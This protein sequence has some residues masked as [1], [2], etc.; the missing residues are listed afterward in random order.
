MTG[1]PPAARPR[2]SLALIPLLA[3]AALA[4]AL[5]WGLY[6]NPREIPSTMIG[7]PVPAFEL[8]PVPDA[9]VPGFSTAE[10]KGQGV[11]LV[12]VF[13]SWCVPCRDEHPLLMELSKREDF[14]VYGIN[15]K[16]RP[17]DA[18]RFLTRLGQPYDRIGSD[19]SGR[20]S[21]DWGVYGVPETFIV[22]N[23]GIIRFKKIGPMLPEDIGAVILPEIEKAKRPAS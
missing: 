8:P 11:V 5:W 10:L 21:I 14:R 17:E 4:F 13:A 23:E 19:A 18:M 16:D 9:G 15:N 1:E 2:R 12:N 3:F 20:V 7:R 22:D 6:G